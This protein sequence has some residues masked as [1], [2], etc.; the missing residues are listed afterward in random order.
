MYPDM[1]FLEGTKILP[2]FFSAKE[3]AVNFQTT[4]HGRLFVPFVGPSKSSDWT[5]SEVPSIN[6]NKS[7]I[8]V[9]RRHHLNLSMISPP[10]LAILLLMV[11]KSG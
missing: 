6:E 7:K 11:Q 10:H 8:Q 1:V 2:T 9:L 5:M 3:K 4:K